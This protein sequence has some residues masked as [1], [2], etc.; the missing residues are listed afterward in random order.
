VSAA[1]TRAIEAGVFEIERIPDAGEGAA[2]I[3]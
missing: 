1:S 2:V 3:A